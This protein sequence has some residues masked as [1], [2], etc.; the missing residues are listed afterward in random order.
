MSIAGQV[1]AQSDIGMWNGVSLEVPINDKL[2]TGIDLQLRLENN[3]RETDEL[4]V[5]PYL[6][7]DL[8]KFVRLD[9]SY[10][11]TSYPSSSAFGHRKTFDIIFRNLMDLL[12]EDSRLSINARVRT[13]YEYKRHDE[14]ETYL[15]FRTKATYNLPKTKLSPELAG[16]LFFHFNDQLIYT[17]EDVSAV[18]R[19]NKYRL[20]GGL[21]YPL[22][23]QNDL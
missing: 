13:T 5:S 22:N 17:S 2:T 12:K 16:E 23:K 15:R 19:F 4:F 10:R 8:H 1:V 14:N 20:R 9:L 11:M 21:T 18:H 6:N 7:Y 3:L